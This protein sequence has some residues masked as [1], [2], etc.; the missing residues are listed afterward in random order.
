MIR[1]LYGRSV[2][3]SNPRSP[4]QERSLTG[5]ASFGAIHDEQM[6]SNRALSVQF[7]VVTLEENTG[8]KQSGWILGHLSVLQQGVIFKRKE[9]CTVQSQSGSCR[10]IFLS[11][12]LRTVH[13]PVP[14]L[15]PLE[16][17]VK[18]VWGLCFS[19]SVP[20]CD[21]ALHCIV[22]HGEKPKATLINSPLCQKT[23]DACKGRR[24]RQ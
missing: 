9:N 15:S 19:V 17:L 18:S 7:G 6:A 14:S 16:G 13:G 11:F 24:R 1:C 2:R 5:S 10:M 21:S 4:R 22:V 20:T 3:A 8:G 12:S 23:N